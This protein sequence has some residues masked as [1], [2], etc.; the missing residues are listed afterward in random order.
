M[1]VNDKDPIWKNPCVKVPGRA[2]RMVD[3]FCQTDSSSVAFFQKWPAPSSY[4]DNVEYNGFSYRAKYMV[5][6]EN[7]PRIHF[8]KCLKKMSPERVKKKSGIPCGNAT[9]KISKDTG[10]DNE[11]TRY[12]VRFNRLEEK[13]CK[14]KSLLELSSLDIEE[15]RKVSWP[16]IPADMKPAV[17]KILLGLIPTA[18]VQR[19]EV[20]QGKRMKYWHMVSKYYNGEEDYLD[21]ATFRQIK[22]DIPR[23]SPNIDLFRQKRVQQVLERILYV[24]AVRCPEVPYVQGL[25]DLLTPFFVVFLQEVAFQGGGEAL[26]TDVSA[27]SSKALSAVEADTFWCFSKLVESLKDNYSLPRT[28]IQVALVRMKELVRRIDVALDGHLEDNGMEYVLFSF[29]WFNNLLSRELPLSC[30]LRLWDTLLAELEA[31]PTFLLFLCV[32]FLLHWKQQLMAEADFQGLMLLLQNLPTHDWTEAD[33]DLLV[34]EAFKLKSAFADAPNHF[35][36][37]SSHNQF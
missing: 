5:L 37:S 28:G 9:S 32:A 7:T 15:V 3:S 6:Y 18:S 13:V 23:M 12:H 1:S 36:S 30:L 17:W 34:A 24:W 22:I 10:S 11:S 20:V 4:I 21:Q 26:P 31:L 2:V 27:V 33:V 35:Q 8:C 16:G 19:Q 14:F 29:R 25:N